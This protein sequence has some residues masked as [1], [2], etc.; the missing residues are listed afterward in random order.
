[1]SQISEEIAILSIAVCD[2]KPSHFASPRTPQIKQ[3]LI[4]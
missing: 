1:M 4:L 2:Q 3:N